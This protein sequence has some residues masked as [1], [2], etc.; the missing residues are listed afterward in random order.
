MAHC[1]D[2]GSGSRPWAPNASRDST[3]KQDEKKDKAKSED[4]DK[5]DK[6]LAEAYEEAVK[7]AILKKYLEAGAINQRTRANGWNVP[8]T[9]TAQAYNPYLDDLPTWGN[10]SAALEASTYQTYDNVYNLLY[11]GFEDYYNSGQW[12]PW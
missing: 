2:E 11:P 1:P 8:Y 10:V 12:S 5:K 4:T 9:L 6:E 3:K 7:R